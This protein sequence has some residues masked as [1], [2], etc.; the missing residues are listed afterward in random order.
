MLTARF[1]SLAAGSGGGASNPPISEWVEDW[2]GNLD[3]YT[4]VGNASISAEDRL[5][6]E[7]LELPGSYVE[8]EQNW[9]W[10]IG[11]AVYIPIDD[12]SVGATVF[13]GVQLISGAEDYISVTVNGGGGSVWCRVA[14]NGLSPVD[15]GVDA[16]WDAVAQR[17]L[18]LMRTT[19]TE[20]VIESSSTTS[21]W[22]LLTPTPFTIP[23]SFN[24]GE[25]KGRVVAAF[26]GEETERPDAQIASVSVYKEPPEGEE[27][28][29]PPTGDFDLF[30]D[31][32]EGFPGDWGDVQDAG[33]SSVFG[34]PGNTDIS[35]VTSPVRAPELA[36]RAWVDQSYGSAVGPRAELA[37][38]NEQYEEG[39]EIWIGEIL[40]I[41][42][43]QGSWDFSHHTIMQLGHPGASAAAN[44]L[45]IRDAGGYSL[46]VH[47]GGRMIVP[48]SEMFGRQIPIEIRIRWHQDSGQ[49]QL[50]VW[51]DG[52]QEFNDTSIR[53]MEDP[54]V[55]LKEGQYG[56]AN[57]KEVFWHGMRI[58]YVTLNGVSM[59]GTRADVLR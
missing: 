40:Y 44:E 34:D 32:A 37:A 11:T 18:R 55:Y 46:G 1:P 12:A 22:V 42:S 7:P 41:P 23:A 59:G 3:A 51:V 30:Y 19:A 45:D 20:F 17:V 57:D 6:L 14:Q 43:G 39:D 31:P 53:T 54:D 2:S 28:P 15:S 13:T 5:L 21:A 27:E 50:E 16:S 26:F 48:G 8:T 56:E 52:E 10:P 24:T 25:F 49:G 36:F 33:T 35:I 58:S 38:W 9:S 4:V 29:P 47:C